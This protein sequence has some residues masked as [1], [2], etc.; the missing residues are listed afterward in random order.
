MTRKRAGTLARVG[1]SVGLLV[2]LFRSVDL[3][4][5]WSLLL[6]A[7]PLPL[8]AALALYCVAGTWVRAERWRA[9]VAA[10]GGRISLRRATQLFLVGMLFSQALPTGIGGDVVRALLLAR[11]G[12]GRA[13]AFS[14]V[15]VDRALG[16]LPLLA[17][18]LVALAIAPGHASAP[19]SALLALAGA[20]GLGAM[21]V[22]LRAHAWRGRASDVPLLGWFVRRPAVARFIDSFADYDTRSLMVASAWSL[23]FIALLI[24]SNLLVGRAVGVT[25]V[26][27]ADWAIVVPLASLSLLLPSVGGWGV[28][29]WTYV[30]LLATMTP[31][32]EAHAATAVSILCGGLNL[33]LA[34]AG[35]LLTALGGRAGLPAMA[36]LRQEV[37][38]TNEKDEASA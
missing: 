16:L 17:T 15:I 14:T 31:P 20:G 29:E 25:S 22:L 18:G 13:R 32:V 12:I 2:V 5:V 37:A 4:D 6:S 8:L 30:G 28:R 34:A 38:R 3:R 26:H 9:L 24:F 36:D 21:I 27:L 10:Q 19:V 11:D 33:L 1:I 35:G 7:R 23:A